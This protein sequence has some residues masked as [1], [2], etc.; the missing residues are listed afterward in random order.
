MDKELEFNFD[1][2]SRKQLLKLCS[3][4]SLKIQGAM[5]NQY[6]SLEDLLK[7]V[8]D[9]LKVTDDGTIAKTDEKTDTKEFEVKLL[10][11]S[12]IRMIII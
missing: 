9:N 10:G 5:P 12:R 8:K 4:Y 7:L 1:M 6:T 11:G 2:L 3:F